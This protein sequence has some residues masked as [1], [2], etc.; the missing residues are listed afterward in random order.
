MGKLKKL[1]EQFLNKLPEVRF[2]D[3]CYLLET[4]VFEEKRSKGSH[5]SF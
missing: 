3:M 5:H 4:F 1:V 2:D